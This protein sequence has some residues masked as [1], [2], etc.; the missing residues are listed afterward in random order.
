MVLNIR[1]IPKASRSLVKEEEGRLKVYLTRPAQDGLA[2]AQLI[3]LLAEHLKVKKYQ[4]HIV[5][6]EKSKN[7]LISISDA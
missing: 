6:G 4:V 3:E 5:K 7:K 1:V 2:N